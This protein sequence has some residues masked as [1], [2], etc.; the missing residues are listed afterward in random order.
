MVK[1]FFLGLIALSFILFGS[2]IL[3]MGYVLNNPTAVFDAFTSVTEKIIQNQHYEENSEFF[4]QGITQLSLNSRHTDI[5]LQTYPGTTLKIALEGK[6]PRF[7]QGPFIIQQLEKDHLRIDLHEPLASQ[8]IQMNVNG[9]EI[10]TH[11]D[12]QLRARIYLPKAYRNSLS[13]QTQAGKVT[14]HLPP[15]QAYE[16]DLQ[17]VS[18]T[19]NNLLTQ[20]ALPH[21][22]LDNVGKISVQT[23]EGAILV[24]PSEN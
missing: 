14:L 16:L 18:G 2:L 8:W 17:T 15:D 24:A 19:I 6:V 9:Q 4:L 3:F 20:K 13:L 21:T 11:S 22:T 1:K 12:S 7:E 23:K 10:T 5:E